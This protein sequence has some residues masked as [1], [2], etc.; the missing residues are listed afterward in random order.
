[1][2]Q[3]KI[4]AA[5][6]IGSTAV[7]LLVVKCHKDGSLELVNE[8]VAVTR[9]GE[10]LYKTGQLSE[11]AMEKTV[12]AALEMQGIAM[13]DGAQNLI[14]SASSIIRDAE[15]RSRFFL[16]CHQKLSIYPQVLS[17]K[18][19]AKFTFMGATM[20][21][22]DN[23]PVFLINIGGGSS[24]IVYGTKNEIV[25]SSCLNIGSMK[26]NEMFGLSNASRSFLPSLSPPKQAR[27]FIKKELQDKVDSEVYA[28]LFKNDPLVLVC[29]GIATTYAALLKK[30]PIYDRDQ[31]NYMESS[32]HD[33][34]A[35]YK[36]LF[37]MKSQQRLRVPGMDPERSEIMP[38][39]LL[40]LSTILKYYKFQ[41][42]SITI[43]GMRL[44]LI[45]FFIEK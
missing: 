15:N 29:G 41:N 1:M 23:M 40:A 3:E 14:V 2:P 18:E 39:G 38:A 11:E 21:L 31:I 44:G 34:M 43:K 16:K 6:D 25:N 32:R 5:L 7:L 28:W 42:F 30:E 20:D 33:I 37:K 24:E 8:Y 9:L 4:I 36:L 17:C 13:K 12:K 26:I 27:N 19:E 45:K 22:D 35:H 10:N